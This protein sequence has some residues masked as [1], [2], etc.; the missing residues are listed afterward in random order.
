ML[1]TSKDETKEKKNEIAPEEPKTKSPTRK[2][3]IEKK[4]DVILSGIMIG[5]RPKRSHCGYDDTYKH[6][7]IPLDVSKI[8]TFQQ[9][10]EKKAQCE[11]KVEVNFHVG[12]TNLYY[13]STEEVMLQLTRIMATGEDHNEVEREK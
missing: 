2:S 12:E 4:I 11:N 8:K 1:N 7:Y 6:D 5:K 13:Q 10:E 9:K 3:K